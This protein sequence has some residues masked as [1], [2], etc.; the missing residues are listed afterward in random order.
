MDGEQSL[1]E[2]SR[3]LSRQSPILRSYKRAMVGGI[4]TGEPERPH[5][6]EGVP[7]VVT[8]AVGDLWLAV[9]DCDLER[10]A[11][12]RLIVDGDVLLLG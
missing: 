10:A 4:L 5:F 3:R 6:D 9:H 11:L 2:H 8:K 12:H 1:I 7:E